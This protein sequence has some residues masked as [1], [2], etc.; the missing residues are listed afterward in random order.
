MTTVGVLTPHATPGPELEIPTMSSGRVATLVSRIPV[1]GGIPEQ[2]RNGT[3]PSVLDAAAGAF[4]PGSVDALAYA[5]TSSGYAIGVAAERE[6]VAALR[7][8]RQLPVVSSGLAAVD[9]LQAF[10]IGFVTLVHPPWFDDEAGELGP[11]Y[12]RT[13]DVDAVAMPADS[14]PNEP[15][16]VRPQQVADWVVGRLDDRTEAVF[17]G[18]NG[19]R[20]AGAV[21]E[22]ERRTG[23]LVLT[24]N[25][26]L[27]W[28]LLRETHTPLAVAGYG[29]LFSVRAPSTVRDPT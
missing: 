12:F 27:L 7:D 14:L 5:S 29:R 18:G 28:A 8:R 21:D 9:A 23:A 2:L 19:F 13:Q 15:D 4:A 3:R 16:R 20:T 24:A 22:I 6:L 10:G 1:R 26:V 11:S 17:L 25:Q